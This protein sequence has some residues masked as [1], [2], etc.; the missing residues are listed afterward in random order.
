MSLIVKTLILDLDGTLLDSKPGI[1]ESFGEA[2]K[3]VF[4]NTEFDLSRIKVGPP[5]RQLCQEAFPNVSEDQLQALAKAYR[6]HYDQKGCTRTGLFE[7]VRSL[8]QHCKTRGIALDV[9]TNKPREVTSMI[10]ARLEISRFFRCVVSVDSTVPAFSGKAAMLKHLLSLNQLDPRQTIFAG[11]TEED[12]HAARA[13]GIPFVWAS[14]GYG[15]LGKDMSGSLT[16]INSL[17]E[18][19]AIL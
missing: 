19:E 12:A 5:L 1:L 16:R 11:D 13:C 6:L 4:P 3:A 17:A 18:L 8:L 14:Y 9:A 10:L 2:V 15:T 7:G